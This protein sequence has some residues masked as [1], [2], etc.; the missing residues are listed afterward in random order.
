[1][2][3]IISPRHEDE[4]AIIKTGFPKSSARIIVENNQRIGLLWGD[5]C[6]D[7]DEMYYIELIIAETPHKGCGLK[8]INYIFQHFDVKAICGESTIEAKDFWIKIGADLD[9]DFVEYREVFEFTL[10]KKNFTDYVSKNN[11]AI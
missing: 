9:E 7:D 4:Y 3:R 10:L 2:L 1:M 11:K 6:Y 8:I 5:Y